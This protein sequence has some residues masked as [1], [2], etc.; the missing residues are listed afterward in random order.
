MRF[1]FS[2]S[3]APGFAGQWQRRRKICGL[4]ALA[5]PFHAFCKRQL[6]QLNSPRLLCLTRLQPS[7][8]DLPAAS[9]TKKAGAPEDPAAGV[10]AFSKSSILELLGLSARFT[11]NGQQCLRAAVACMCGWH[12]AQAGT[13]RAGIPVK[14]TVLCMLNRVAC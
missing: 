8:V 3:Y 5:V 14:L 2:Q 9:W 4:F 1:R 11:S 6:V 7:R 10:A 13:V 12:R